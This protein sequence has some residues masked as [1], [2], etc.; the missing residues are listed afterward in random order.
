MANLVIKF[1]CGISGIIALKGFLQNEDEKIVQKMAS[2][3]I[4][5]GP[6]YT[7]FYRDSKILLGNTRLPI[8]DR[9][10]RSH[11]PLSDREG[12]VTICYNGEVSNYIELKNKY[13]LEQKYSFWGQSDTEVLIYLY[14]ELGIEF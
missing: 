5:R 12:H 13:K 7:G 10:G 8:I 2:M 4:H 11:L 3:L 1:M 9:K 14:K 6:K